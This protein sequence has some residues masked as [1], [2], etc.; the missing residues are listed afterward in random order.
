MTY[1]DLDRDS[2]DEILIPR[3]IVCKRTKDHRMVTHDPKALR[4]S[5]CLEL[6]KGK[7]VK[8]GDANMKAFNLPTISEIYPTMQD[9]FVS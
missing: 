1:G 4:S 8:I 5:R 6:E 2:A 3:R 9:P 7:L